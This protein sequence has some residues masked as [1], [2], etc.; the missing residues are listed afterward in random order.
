MTPFVLAPQTNER[1]P[2]PPRPAYPHHMPLQLRFSDI[3]VF[4]HM[5]NSVYLNLFDLGKTEFFRWALGH[6]VD[7]RDAGMV[8]AQV[9]LN[10]FAPTV[11]YQPVEVM[12]MCESVG[13]RSLVL[14][15]R[16]VDTA[17]GQTNATC[18]SVMV[19]FDPAT[20]KSADLHAPWVEAVRA[21][22]D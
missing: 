12:T 2:L 6:D 5:N 9:T 14:E 16:I 18:R 1:V 11:Y 19:G 20:G 21:T 15:Q 22:I 4:G 13:R 10:F 7:W 8:V 17:T 3:D